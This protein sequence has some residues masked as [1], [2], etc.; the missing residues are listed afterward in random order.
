[1]PVT[2]GRRCCFL[3]FLYDDAGAKL[4][5]DN[6]RFLEGELAN[7]RADKDVVVR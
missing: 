4:R 5:E 1:M 3:P 7:Y 6:T 2:K